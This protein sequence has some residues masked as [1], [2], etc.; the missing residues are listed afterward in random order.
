[1]VKK[2]RNQLNLAPPNL[3]D[4]SEIVIPDEYKQYMTNNG[5]RENFLKADSSQ[6]NNRIPIFR[7]KSWTKYIL[8]S[9]V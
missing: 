9:D 8:N 5:K 6:S 3:T 7:R 1:M 2:R 4:V